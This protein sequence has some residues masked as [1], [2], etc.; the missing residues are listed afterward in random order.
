MFHRTE[1]FRAY[2]PPVHLESFSMA[3][4]VKYGFV[5]TRKS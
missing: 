4:R 5:P 3:N 1:V 2:L